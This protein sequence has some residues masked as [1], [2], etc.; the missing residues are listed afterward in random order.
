MSPA[1]PMAA[2][3]LAPVVHPG[4]LANGPVRLALLVGGVVA[5]VS[6][7]V[8]VFTVLRGQAFASHS[9]ADIGTTGGSGA[10]LAGVPPLW[11]FLGLGA[12]AAAVMELI[13][14]GRVRRRDVATGIVLGASLGLS[15]LFLYWDSTTR[16]TTG[17]TVDVLFGSMFT[18]AP[19][20]VPA[21]VAFSAATLAVVGAGYRPLLLSSLSPEAAAARGVPV[22]LTGLVY[23][24]ALTLAVALSSV[25][26]GAVL[27]TALLI[28]PAAA[29][30]RLTRRTGLALLLA[31]AFGL[32]SVWVGIVLAWDSFY[33]SPGG[34]AWPVSFFV[35][36]V[37]VAGYLLAQLRRAGGRRRA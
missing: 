7:P 32:A 27:S 30:V 17:A 26:I 11:G 24:L 29:A 31:A 12:A 10:F 35:V 4:F 25:T 6:A 22:R 8:G 5:V 3:L 18:I 9:L 36:A 21:L 28:G 20:L 34:D 23:F 37:I 1:L 13:G 19:S 33:W 14:V 15:A 2:G 16:S